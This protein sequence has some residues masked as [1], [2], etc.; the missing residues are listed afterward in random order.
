MSLT[1]ANHRIKIT[2]YNTGKVK[3]GEYYIP[4]IEGVKFTREDHLI[5]DVLLEVKKQPKEYN[6]I[7]IASAGLT[8]AIIYFL[9]N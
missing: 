2:P 9:N 8:V 3:I 6:V 5:Q 7:G 4:P 1:A